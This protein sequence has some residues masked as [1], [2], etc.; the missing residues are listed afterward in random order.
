M[1]L[2]CDLSPEIFIEG[3]AQNSRESLADIV[4]V[5]LLYSHDRGVILA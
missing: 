3:V 2:F 1:W 5:E 4:L